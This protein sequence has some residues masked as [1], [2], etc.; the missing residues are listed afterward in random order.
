MPVHL[1]TVCLGNVCRSPAAEAVPAL[2]RTPREAEKVVRLGAF[3]AGAAGGVR[4]VVDPWGG[5]REAY[6]PM[7][8]RIEEAVDGVVQALR[9]GTVRHV[10]AAPRTAG[11]ARGEAARRTGPP[12]SREFGARPPEA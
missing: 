7:Y 8:D 5:P 2:A 12:G 10:A 9:D 11:R 6:A 3:A 1:V 4:D